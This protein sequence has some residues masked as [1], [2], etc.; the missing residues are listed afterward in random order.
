MLTPWCMLS[1]FWTLHKRG[2]CIRFC[3]IWQI[4][5]STEYLLFNNREINIY[6]YMYTPSSKNWK[7]WEFQGRLSFWSCIFFNS[8]ILTELRQKLSS[9][10]WAQLLLEG[11][12]LYAIILLCCYNLL[13]G[14]CTRVLPE[15]ATRVIFHTIAVLQLPQYTSGFSSGPVLVR[16]WLYEDLGFYF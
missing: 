1:D 8:N 13:Q 16:K 4:K 5:W 10:I 3:A 6:M 15:T 12:S 2:F 9:W 14:L 7:G 11:E